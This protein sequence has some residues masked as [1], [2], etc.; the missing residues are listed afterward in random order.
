MAGNATTIREFLVA[1][2]FVTDEPALKRFTAGIDGATK[3]VFGLATI[4]ET[5]AVGIAASIARYASDLEQLYFASQRTNSAAANLKAFGRAAEDFGASNSEALQSV[6]GLAK[7]L[8]TNPGGEGYL[9]T[10]IPTRDQNG[11]LKD[12]TELLTELGE[13]LSHM[14]YYLANQYAGIFGI[15]ENTMRAIMSGE[16]RGELDQ[17]RDRLNRSDWAQTTKDA[18][19]FNEQLRDLETTL[20]AF[21]LRVIDVFQKKLGKNV[22]DLADYLEAHG[23]ELADKL[24]V[25]LTKIWDAAQWLIGKIT[26]IIQTLQ[27]WDKTTHGL[28]TTLL[29]TLAIMRYFGGGEI[30]GGVLNLAA[31]FVKLGG[32]AT[33]AEGASAGLL[34]RTGGLLGKT[35]GAALAGYLGYKVIGPWINDKIPDTWKD[36]L[37]ERL[38]EIV[39]HMGG[40]TGKNAAEALATNNP[41]NFL[42]QNGGWTKEQAQGILKRLNWESQLDPHSVGDNGKAYGIAQ[43]HPKR[44]ADFSKWA[45]HDIHDSTLAEQLAFLSY[46]MNAGAE[47]AAGRAVRATTNVN[48]AYAAFTRQ[49][50]RPA[51]ANIGPALSRGDTHIEVNTTQHIHGN[52]DPAATA[53][54]TA[55]EQTR[56]ASE[57]LRNTKPLVQ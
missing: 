21:G 12:T 31:A 42:M 9:A 24:V 14:P 5:T 17:L 37:G 30:I 25:I 19:L 33:A 56:V 27:S 57:V 36:A 18:H 6:E 50:E 45:G 29:E 35:T 15:S 8:R 34:A 49:Y 16:F 7:F 2:G 53:R 48:S 47:R 51:D 38:T 39:A 40:K 46:E 41:L 22:G 20:E 4:V 3:A 32:A 52:T 44:Q 13:K 43:W 28:S 1:L 11:H 54:A 26:D 23:D 55:N 10:L